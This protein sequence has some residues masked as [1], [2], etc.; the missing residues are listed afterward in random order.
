MIQLKR[1]LTRYSL[2]FSGVLLAGSVQAKT[3]TVNTADNADFS[4][5]KTN[6]VT[7]ISQLADGDT[8]AFNIPGSGV[9]T[10]L[11][12]SGGY[13]IITNSRVTID[14]YTQPGSSVNT[15]SIH[16]ANNAQLNILLDSRSGNGLSMGDTIAALTG[17]NTTDFGWGSTEWA[18]LGF[19]RGTNNL[20]KGLAFAAAP[21]TA[22]D[23]VAIKMICFAR[24]D[25]GPG[26]NW[27][28]SG[29]WFGINPATRKIAYMPD[30]VTPALGT[31]SI[32]TYNE[33]Q[34]GTNKLYTSPGT[35]GV[36]KNSANPRADFNVFATFY[37]F[38]SAGYSW[39]IGGNFWNVLPDG[40]TSFDV[41]QADPADTGD[42]YIEAGG[43]AHDITIGTDGDGVNDAEE[44]NIFGGTS[45][46]AQGF[47]IG[48]RWLAVNLYSGIPH[49]NIVI[50]GNTWGLSAD[51][52]IRFTNSGCFLHSFN[53]T[54]TARVGSDFDGVSDALEANKLYNNYPFNYAFMDPGAGDLTPPT[55][56]DGTGTRNFGGMNPGV[57][58]SFRGNV[59]VGNDL[60]PYKYA[61][62]SGSLL[63]SFTNYEGFYM[64]TNSANGLIPTLN[65]ASNIYPQ[66]AGTF[67]P[68][69]A[70]Y[71][72]IIVDVYQADPEGWANGQLFN[73]VELQD[74]TGL[75]NGFPQGKKYIGSYT[76]PNTGSFNIT[77]PGIADFGGG[78]VTVAVNYSADPVGTKN[79]RVHTSNFS[80]PI[81]LYPGS[82]ESAGLTHVV[83]DVP[84]WFDTVLN[85]PTNG[86]INLARQPAQASL[87]NWEP[88]I[89]VM[90]DST[91]LIEFNTY[92][93]DGGYQ[94]QNN[95][96]A[97]QPAA[98][99]TAK[100]DYAFYADNNT[101]FKGALNLSRQNG[102]PGKVAGDLRYGGTKFMTE[103]EVSLGQ[104][105]EFQSNTRWANNDIFQG[106]NRYAAEQLFTLDPATLVQTP[107]AKAWD[108]VYG[109]FSGVMGAGN[110]APQCSRTG[111]R[112]NFLDNGNI[113]V[114]IDDKTAIS[115]TVGEVTT[116]SII[117]PDGTVV[118]S[119][120]LAKEQDIFDNMCAVKGGFVIRVHNSL[121]FY[122]NSGTLTYSNDVNVSS[123]MNFGGSADVGGR[124]DGI[125]INGDIRSYYVYVAGTI[126]GG[127]GSHELGVAAWDT[128]TGQFVGGSTVTDGDPAQ[129]QC[130]RAGLA[131]DA[132][133]RVCVA[134]MHKPTPAF[135]YQ[136]VARVAQFDGSKF[137]WY[138]HSFYP[139]I[140][141]DKDPNNVLGFLTANPYV[142]MTTR[143]IC[144]AAK[145]TINSANNVAAGP[146][147]LSEQTV[148]TVISHPEPVA[149]PVPSI[150]VTQPDSS[151]LTVSWSADA[152]L[153][154]VQT[155][156]SLSSGTWSAAT[157]GNVL[158]PVTLPIGAGSTFI[159]LAR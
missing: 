63:N 20:V 135:G 107:V 7:A 90:G 114:M 24:D 44:A 2:L 25:N 77:L 5:G 155:K 124:G 121:L 132:L 23:P 96:V 69:I 39:R 42:A 59:S 100:V 120:T 88:Y 66:L 30:N 29:C 75:T 28:V 50:A 128:R 153:F 151:H 46:Y 105:P 111:G 83:N 115:S 146:N 81:Y 68:G 67:A 86:P 112:P 134:Y 129:E 32:A 89:G 58:L 126:N 55:V 78:M 152:G 125:R 143:Q 11:T 33:N 72:T 127:G 123:A 139:F 119:A 52:S 13:P 76:V 109:P 150:T 133:N 141:H 36:S 37:G 85:A 95:A 3:I 97:K 8:I 40:V 147:S 27:Q 14:G 47:Y 9:K 138:G 118:K 82:A 116:F 154:T 84:C 145:G 16:S 131:V 51:G 31:I 49:T 35:V 21:T 113:V 34:G 60:L 158:P 122:N 102:N 130:D 136:V 157:A 41:A 12:P 53:A 70:P 57:R 106:N 65:T 140:N 92:A 148:Y 19:F 108:Y 93:N 98:G 101:P 17:D 94:N 54:A 1:K 43:A 110:N 64:N 144:I 10:L 15:G 149:A 117:Q 74:P 159:R 73:E 80:N 26:S 38:D 137:N 103:A 99:G 71:T 91:F 104:L 22:T 61:N 62:N 142:A 79:G 48:A 4:A 6:L 18:I 156:S 56:F 87:G 45:A